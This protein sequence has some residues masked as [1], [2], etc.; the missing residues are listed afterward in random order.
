MPILL[1]AGDM[2][3]KA[4]QEARLIA[5]DLA[6]GDST[7]Q[8]EVR[9]LIEVDWLDYLAQKK[10]ELGGKAYTHGNQPLCIHSV[11]GYIGGLD[12]LLMWA[13]EKYMYE[14]PPF[15]EENKAQMEKE[16]QVM[17]QQ[18]FDT[19]MTKQSRQFVFM[20]FVLDGVEGEQRV[21]YEL[22]TDK[23]PKTCE[24]FVALCTGEKGQSS[25]GTNLH[26]KN[27]LI[28][29]VVKNGWIQGGDLVDGRGNHSESI[30]GDIFPDE[31]FSVKHNVPGI[32]S[33]ANSGPHTN[34]SQFFVTL[35][36]FPCFDSKKVAFGRVVSGRKVFETMSTQ[37]T[38]NQYP[39]VPAMIKD[40]GVLTASASAAE[41]EDETP[42]ANPS[43]KANILFCGLDN[44]GK[45]TIVKRLLGESGMDATPTNGFERD[46]LIKG[47]FDLTL[48]GLGG[49]KGIRGYWSDYYDGVSGVIYVIDSSDKERL[50]E[51]AE[52][53]SAMAEHEMMKGKPCAVYVNKQ[54]L[55]GT[56]SSAEVALELKIDTDSS[57]FKLFNTSALDQSPD[58]NTKALKEGLTWLLSEVSKEYSSLS[59]RCAKDSAARKAQAKAE[60]SARR[61][62][63]EK[64][65]AMKAGGFKP[66]EVPQHEFY[67]SWENVE[68]TKAEYLAKEAYEIDVNGVK[69]KLHHNS[70]GVDK[71][72]SCMA[73]HLT[74]ELYNKLK[75][76]V[77]PNGVTLDK[78]IKTGIENPGHPAIKT[79]GMTAGDVESYEVFKELFDPV[80]DERHGGYGAEAKHPSDMDVSK[81]KDPSVID[82]EYVISTRVR[83]G[84]SVQGIPLPPS[85][86]KEER[87]KL[88][89]IVTKALTKLEGELA[90]DY[91]PLAGS[92]SYSA[93]P[94]GMT[95][96]EEE[97]LRADH[98]LFQEPDST[99]LISGAM[100]RDWPDAR[101]IYH[102]KDKNALVWL[103]EEDH[104][105]I[106][107]M[108]M[109]P[110][111]KAV[112]TRFANLCAEVEKV[113]TAEGFSF[114]HSEHLGYILTCP[115]NLGTG[116]RASMMVKLP[117]LGK[118]PDFKK[119]AG[120][121]GIQIRGSAGVDSGFTGV[122]DLSN[123][124]RLGKSEVELI[125]IMIDGVAALINKEKEL[126]AEA[127]TAE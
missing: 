29:R 119:M 30:W 94:G 12:G 70:A 122:F 13:N 27:T 16:F 115:S 10:R 35:R 103:N 18:E 50:K 65:K 39:K 59:E 95:S 76:R 125:N 79:V 57:N 48:Y 33:M 96:E 37:E 105:R 22:F 60:L 45:S 61:E 97:K 77:T 63:I 100:H 21:V 53:F 64:E 73:N 67:G 62:A 118:H 6:N 104:L 55:S 83:S 47:D 87:R 56:L 126:E 40:C 34:G 23:C 51:T 98:F 14:V 1:I 113:V 109:G 112:F 90:G 36:E 7:L 127:K 91:F 102:N 81:I 54:D 5:D 58:A 107:S 86:N 46:S 66:R 110:D 3:D 80:I 49:A 19:Y 2:L 20:D 68:K 114:A 32:L 43:K 99:L 93:K 15:T 11:L 52:A 88:E 123:S 25:K 111:I 17:A 75:D 120:D 108:Q 106:I 71:H 38:I 82:S 44:A 41:E 4:F 85:C 9:S 101:G 69:I 78:C 26:Y 117:N 121:L 92:Q 89:E 84:R 116:L 28:H 24:N 124:A 8:I 72:T 74:E 42:S 31:S